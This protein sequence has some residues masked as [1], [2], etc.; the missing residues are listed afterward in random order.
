MSATHKAAKF[1][2][3]IEGG[4]SQGKIADYRQAF[5]ILKA[6]HKQSKKGD[7]SLLLALLREAG[8]KRS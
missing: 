2:A 5:R 3:N 1:V 4:K 6:Q 8:K 7:P